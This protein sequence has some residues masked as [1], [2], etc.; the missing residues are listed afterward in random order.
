[1]PTGTLSPSPKFVGLSDAGLPLNGGLLYTYAAGTSTPATTYSDAAL[2]TPN[3]NPIVLDAAGRATVY[4]AATS[5]KFTLRTSAGVLVYTQDNISSVNA[6]SSGLGEVFDFGG[7]PATPITATSYPVGATF[8]KLHPGTAVLSEDSANLSG[9]YVLKVTGKQDTSGTLTV[10]IVNLDDGAPDTPL[11][12][13]T[14]T[15]LTG[16]LATSGTITFPAAGTVKNYGIKGKVS[17]N[18]GFAWG[19]KLWKTA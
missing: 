8:D 7:N 5:Y 11:A 1:M 10:A 16:A 14:I 17:A 19:A 13:A 6:G 4:L 15:S 2:T 3:A 12:T 18:T 9:T